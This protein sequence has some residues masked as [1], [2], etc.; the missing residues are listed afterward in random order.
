MK[1]LNKQ[2]TEK[3]KT[4]TI[5]TLLMAILLAITAVVSFRAGVNHQRKQANYVQQVIESEVARL[6][7]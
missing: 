1:K 4:M 7:Q 3:L 6:K 5:V 2:T